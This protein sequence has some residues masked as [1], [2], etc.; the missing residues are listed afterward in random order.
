MDERPKGYIPAFGFDWLLPLYD[1]FLRWVIREDA[2]K[3]RLVR[4]AQIEA[5]QR[6][7]DLGCGTGTLTLLIKRLHPEADVYGLDGDPQ[8]LAIAERKT[9]SA[10]VEIHLD[11]GLSYQLPYPAEFFDRVLS[12]L[13][14]HHLT[15]EDKL[16]SL[17]EVIRVLKPG[18]ML[19]IVDF[20][21]PDTWWSGRM[22]K[23]L[24]HKEQTRDNVEGRL[25]DFLTTVGFVG[26]EK[27][28]RH[29]TIVGSLSFYRGC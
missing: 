17:H 29:G 13:V 7:L 27:F 21:E 6:V 2:F 5:S 4:E 1:P 11:Q 15:R 18:G 9:H 24:H 23:L 10:G 19:S 16:R 20:G 3:Q 28:G 8:V 25:A 22:A 14:F 26:V 12:S